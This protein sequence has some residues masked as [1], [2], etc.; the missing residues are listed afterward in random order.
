MNA[1]KKRR[2][3][4]FQNKPNSAEGVEEGYMISQ[5]HL[6]NFIFHKGFV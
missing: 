4:I 1:Y 5:I 2:E 3:A 6:R